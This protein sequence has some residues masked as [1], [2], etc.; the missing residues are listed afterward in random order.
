MIRRPPRSTLFPYTT[1]F[2]SDA[3]AQEPPDPVGTLEDGHRVAG[4]VE[5]LGSR[6]PRG[7]GADD[8]DPLSRAHCRWPRGDPALVEGALDD[9]QLDRLD[10]DWVVVDLEHA[11]ALA[12]RGTETARPLGEVVR[13]VQAV[14]RVAPVVLVHEGGPVGGDVVQRAALVGGRDAAVP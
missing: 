14:D 5:L 11:R 9:G 13:R 2:R 4:A 3:V 8:R 6:E 1:L 10:R 7:P 12:R